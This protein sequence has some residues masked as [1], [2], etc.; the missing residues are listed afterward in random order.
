MTNQQPLTFL[1]IS[2]YYKGVDF[3]KACKAA[4]NRVFLVTSKKLEN[5]NWPKDQLDDIFYMNEDES[6]EWNLD[7]L[8]AGTAFVFKHNRID[9]VVALDDFDVEKAALV[10]ETFRI[11][12][13]G[14]TTARYFRDKLAMRMKA[15]EEGIRV[16]GFSG[17]FNDEQINQFIA[18]NP[19]PWM[20]KPR[21]EASATGVKKVHTADELWQHIH[22][23]GEKRHQYLVEQFKPGAVYHVDSLSNEGQLIFCRV[24]QY[25]NTPFEVAHGGGVF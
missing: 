5:E 10:R 16:P 8:I 6:G 20:V 23:L 1:C 18:N 14:Q 3:L 12:G 15:Q 4:G 21:S 2:C 11:P 17:L 9:R 13:M 7:D 25:L 24:S 19:G 22:S